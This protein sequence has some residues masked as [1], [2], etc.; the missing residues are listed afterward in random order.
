MQGAATQYCPDQ[1]HDGRPT[2]A[3]GGA[4]APSRKLWKFPLDRA[5]TMVALPDLTLEF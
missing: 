4:A 3:P 5:A 1:S 2:T